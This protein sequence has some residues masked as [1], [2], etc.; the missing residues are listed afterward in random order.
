MEFVYIEDDAP[1]IAI[2]D[3][4]NLKHL[5]IQ[6][7]NGEYYMTFTMENALRIRSPKGDLFDDSHGIN[8]ISIVFNSHFA[9]NEIDEIFGNM[10]CERIFSCIF[11]MIGNG[12]FIFV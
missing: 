12:I 8:K 9:E 3:D 4:D 6:K 10:V 1:H 2:I 5:H 7:Q 11:H